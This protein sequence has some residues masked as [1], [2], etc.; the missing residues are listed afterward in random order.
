MILIDGSAMTYKTF[1]GNS[2][3]IVKGEVFHKNLFKHTLLNNFLWKIKILGG[4]RANK[5]VICSD[6]KPYWRTDYFNSVKHKYFEDYYLTEKT[7][8]VIDVDGWAYKGKRKSIDFAQE[9]WEV[10]TEVIEFINKYTDFIELKVKTAE[11][12]DLIAVLAKHYSAYEDIFIVAGD[13]DFKQLLSNPRIH[14]YNDSPHRKPNSPDWIE[15]ED[16]K[17]FLEELIMQGDTSD[18]IPNIKPKLGEKTALK[19]AIEPELLIEQ[20]KLNPTIEF[21][22]EVNRNMIDFNY[23]PDELQKEIIK[24]FEAAKNKGSFDEMEIVNYLMEHAL[25]ELQGRRQEFQLKPYAI[26]TRLNTHF[27]KKKKNVDYMSRR[28]EEIL[29]DLFAD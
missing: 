4:S 15:C 23:I 19:Y 25:N 12:D 27:T 9:I 21:R 8:K 22:H 5:V 20:K 3:E 11:A 13:K 18:N 24:S 10:H 2:K 29:A 6:A 1:H 26:E 7:K 28:N 17:R 16:P 14:L